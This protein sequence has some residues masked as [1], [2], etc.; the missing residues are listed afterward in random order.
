[1]CAK[2]FIKKIKKANTIY[3]YAILTLLN[4]KNQIKSKLKLGILSYKNIFSQIYI[5]ALNIF[6]FWKAENSFKKL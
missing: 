3:N 5:I 1:M 4:I 2:I 6:I